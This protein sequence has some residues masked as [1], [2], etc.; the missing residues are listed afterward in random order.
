MK[1]IGLAESFEGLHHLIIKDKHGDD[2]S[3]YQSLTKTVVLIPLNKME[4]WKESIN[5]YL[6]LSRP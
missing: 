2:H 3:T 5:T 4:G 1:M 6:T